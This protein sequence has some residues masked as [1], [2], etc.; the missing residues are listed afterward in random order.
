MTANLW[1]KFDNTYQ[2]ALSIPIEECRRFAVHPLTWLRY[3]AF[4]IYGRE[5]VISSQPNGNEVQ[6]YEPDIQPGDYYYIA[7][8]KSYFYVQKFLVHLQC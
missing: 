1:M 3:V 7:Q 2:R 5:G 4:T 8:G 6:Y